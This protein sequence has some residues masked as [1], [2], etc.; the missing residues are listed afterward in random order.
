MN[1]T[2]GGPLE[3]SRRVV[4]VERRGRFNVGELLFERS[5]QVP[6]GRGPVRPR[7]G[8][9][10]LVDLGHNAGTPVQQLGSPHNARDVVEALLLDRGIERGFSEEI[11]EE[12]ERA[13]GGGAGTI[14]EGRRDL[15]DLATFTVDPASAADFDDAV[16]ADRRGDGLRLWIH[17][18]DVAAHVRPGGPLD[19]EALAR[20]TSVYVPGTAEPMLPR[21]L[22]SDACSLV[23]GQPRLAVTTEI[24]LDASGVPQKASFYRSLIRSDIRLSYDELDEI[25][26]SR[27]EPPAEVAEPLRLARDAAARLKERRRSGGLEVDSREPDFEFD[28]DGNVVGAH[29]V[30]QTESHRLIEQLMVLNNEQVA[31]FLEARKVPTL[32]RVHELPEPQRIRLL[33]EQL[34]ALDIPTPP[35]PDNLGPSDAGRL[36]IEASQVAAREA[37]RR[38]HGRDAYTS[39]VL[40]SLKQAVY[41][42]RNLG[43]AGLGSNAYAHFTSPIRRYP[44]L[45]AHRALLSALNQ[46]EVAPERGF[47]SDA[48]VHA[49]G[50]ERDAARIERSAD[51]V[52]AA[53][54]LSSELREHGQGSVFEG[55]VSGVIGAGAFINFRGR[56]ADVY[57]GFLPSRR[58][59][60]ERLDLNETETA[61]VGQRS[62]R[63][64]VRLGDPVSVK[65]EGV[66][67]ARGRVNLA[68]DSKPEQGKGKP[69]GPQGH[70]K[71]RGG[72]GRK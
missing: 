63:T 55:E 48:G 56:F 7:V 4:V 47:V 28:E 53:F 26:A 62:G 12:A 39:L 3:R 42:D 23:P 51:D 33:L 72:G 69:R 11:D 37:K 1:A 31:Q 50:R 25:F 29:G 19:T 54:L 2:S 35:I 40:R 71:P 49:S 30:E 22:S 36:A 15:T 17:I 57:E 18:A 10:A 64:V 45:I 13:A 14:W 52:C 65:V 68:P 16:S 24:E 59:G 8:R 44:D 60:G 46:G 66:E 38:G 5:S 70:R 43:H 41:L 58:M 9:M 27:A 20:A 67:A 21:R 34:A 32:F 6:L 61:L